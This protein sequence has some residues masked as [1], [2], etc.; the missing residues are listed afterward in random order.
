MLAKLKPAPTSSLVLRHYDPDALLDLHTDASG[1]GLGAG[2][3]EQ[4]HN[5]LIK[6]V[7]T[8]ES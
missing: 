5:D 4:D 2:L 8:Y 1:D 6:H 7:V 3:D